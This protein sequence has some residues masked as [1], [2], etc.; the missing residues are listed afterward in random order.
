[1][2]I[3][4]V[5]TYGLILLFQSCAKKPIS[6]KV[7]PSI[8]QKGLNTFGCLVDGGVIINEGGDNIGQRGNFS[9]HYYKDSVY[10]FRFDIFDYYSYL[11]LNDEIHFT[12][13]GFAS[14]GIQ[15]HTKDKIKLAN[16][17]FLDSKLDSLYGY[18]TFSVGDNYITKPPISGEVN[19]SSV[20]TIH[21]IIAGT[22]NFQAIGTYSGKVISVTDGRFDGRY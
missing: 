15:L 17:F 7:L 3:L 6:P 1:M 19:I 13:I 4:L 20:D 9:M 21:H 16:F 11:P 22:F 18:A 8:T 14:N 12:R 2:K 5:I 10:H